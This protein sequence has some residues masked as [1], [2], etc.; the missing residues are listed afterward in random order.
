MVIA[1]LVLG[2]CSTRLN[3]MNWFGNSEETLV[4]APEAFSDERRPLA[5][6]ITAL[7][8]DRMPSGAIIRAT[9]LPPTQGYWDAELVPVNLGNETNGELIFELRLAP[10]ATPRPVSTARSRDVFVATDLSN[11]QLRNVRRVTVVGSAN[12]QTVRR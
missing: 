11:T 1:V 10:P 7:R 12:R 8:I 2:G 5:E 4:S 3:P 9:G 6:R